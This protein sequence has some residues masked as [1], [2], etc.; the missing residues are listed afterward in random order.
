MGR[1]GPLEHG[2]PASAFHSLAHSIIEQMLSIRAAATIERRVCSLCDDDF[3]PETV[4]ALGEGD[5]RA[6]GMSGRKAR[7]LVGLAAYACEHDLEVLRELSDD[8]VRERLCALPGVGKWTADMFLLFYLGRPDILPVEDGAFRQ[9]FQWLYGAPVTDEAVRTVVCDLWH[10]YAS[11]AV[12]YL[13]RAL[14][15]GLVRELDARD[16]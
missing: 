9:A 7:S 4:A 14:N 10:P 5:L 2:V 3:R 13:Y 11:T 12:R 6:C 1:I 15:S 8:V 16:L